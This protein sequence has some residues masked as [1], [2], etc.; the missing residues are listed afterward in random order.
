MRSVDPAFYKEQAWERAREAFLKKQR[1]ICER[2]GGAANVAH[3][4]EHL[5][6]DNVTDAATAYGFENLEA[7]CSKC[8][9]EE[10]KR[11]KRRYVFLD[12]GTIKIL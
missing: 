2:C 4:R 8:H 3:H 12:D 6:A 1:Y 5:N 11:Q 10:H 7:L 9:N